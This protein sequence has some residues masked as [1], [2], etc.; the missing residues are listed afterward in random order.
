MKTPTNDAKWQTQN[1]ILPTIELEGDTIRVKNVRDYRY[2]D[3]R[4][5]AQAN[6]LDETYQLSKFK[7]AWFGLSHFGN[8]GLAHVFL[9]FEFSDNKYLVVSIEAR[10]EEK[11]P[12]YDPVVGLFRGYTKLLVL[13]LSLIHI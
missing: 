2:N 6:Y 4:T 11:H 5:I 12:G 8:Y 3:D 13:A 10:L 1:R 7:R 9:S